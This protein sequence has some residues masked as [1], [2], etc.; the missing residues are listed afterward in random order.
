[1]NLLHNNDV[2]FGEPAYKPKIL[3][4]SS[5]HRWNDVRIFHKEACSLA[6]KHDV[7]VMG[8]A[9]E[10]ISNSGEIRI[11]TLPRPTSLLRRFLNGCKVLKESV[12]GGYAIFHF[13]DPELLWIGFVVKLFRI[14]VIYDVHEDTRAAAQIREW[15]PQ[16]LRGILGGLVHVFELFGQW[17]FNGVILAEDSYFSNFHANDKTVAI[18][19]YVRVDDSALHFRNQSKRILY[20][21]SVTVARGI[22]DLLD[23]VAILQKE[24]PEIG[25]TIIGSGP[26]DDKKELEELRSRLPDPASVEFIDYIDFGKL[27]KFAQDCHLAVVPLRRTKNY[28]RSIPT[29]ILDYMN[30][31]LPFGYSRLSLTEEL[32]GQHSGGVGFEPGDVKDLARHL[33]RLLTEKNLYDQLRN[34]GKSKVVQFDWSNEEKTLFKLKDRVLGKSEGENRSVAPEV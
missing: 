22:G 15:I 34:E 33:R 20:A 31:G 28:E 32:F 2:N 12:S 6:I 7:T 18:R 24:D 30:W 10:S 26:A 14:K 16:L 9:S 19:N 11:L 4:A 25:A 27:K 23:A 17:I 1:M 5:L 29:K 13:H 3:L 21:G 8:V